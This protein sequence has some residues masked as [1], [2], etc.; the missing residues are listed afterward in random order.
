MSVRR[1]ATTQKMLVAPID[2]AAIIAG[3]RAA[4]LSASPDVRIERWQAVMERGR[5]LVAD[6]RAPV[7][8]Y[9]ALLRFLESV[10][11][12]DLVH[13]AIFE[14]A[15]AMLEFIRDPAPCMGAF[16]DLGLDTGHAALIPGY[17]IYTERPLGAG[18]YATVY[19]GRH[20]ATGHAVALKVY[21][22]DRMHEH[23]ASDLDF[24]R[25]LHGCNE[26]R[27]Q[28]AGQFAGVAPIVEM[29]LTVTQVPYAVLP[30]Y[31][32]GMLNA[33]LAPPRD[34]D[35]LALRPRLQGLIQIAAGI[36]YR[37]FSLSNVVFT[38][39]DL[40]QTAPYLVDF[41]VALR[42]PEAEARFEL[43][44]DQGWSYARGKLG[45]LAPELLAGAASAPADDVY[46][47]GVT[48]W[49]AV[50]GQRVPRHKSTWTRRQTSLLDCIDILPTARPLPESWQPFFRQALALERQNRFPDARTMLAALP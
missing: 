18:A 34:G 12:D 36:V 17:I 44:R 37:D 20:V 10:P 45:Y 46:A 7:R 31:L 50:T 1:A 13:P 22:R 19:P 2:E 24:I 49:E 33:Y 5:A 30:R 4:L 6:G 43:Q 9:Q 11:E 39:G 35:L 42:V 26:A 47:L 38:P 25:R 8:G 16:P 32:P 48:L 29:G 27:F 41:G 15:E 21:D 40:A 14:G 28:A 3:R 23:D